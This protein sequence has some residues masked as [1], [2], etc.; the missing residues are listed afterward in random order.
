MLWKLIIWLLRCKL[1][2]YVK[3]V[4]VGEE[5]YAISIEKF[6]PIEKQV[7]KWKDALAGTRT[8]D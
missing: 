6:V 7:K 2:D 1:E 8:S 3:A 5:I 4:K